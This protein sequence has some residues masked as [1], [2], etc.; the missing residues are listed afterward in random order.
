MIRKLGAVCFAAILCGLCISGCHDFR[1][2]GAGGLLSKN[3]ALELAVSL[4]NKECMKRFSR[5]PFAL[6]TYSIELRDGQWRWGDLDPHGTSGFSAIVTFDVNGGNR[7]IQV[8]L[9]TDEL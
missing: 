1:K 2:G 7:T 4:A 3:E 8:F 6:S 5:A 9:S